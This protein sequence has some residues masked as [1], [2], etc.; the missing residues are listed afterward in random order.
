MLKTA[1]LTTARRR[2]AHSDLDNCMLVKDGI[3]LSL[4]TLNTWRKG[5]GTEDKAI[6]NLPFTR[7]KCSAVQ[8]HI[9][10]EQQKPTV[11][12]LCNAC[13]SSADAMCE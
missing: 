6:V 13:D 12:L 4:L 3:L 8:A 10:G 11:E 2:T 7:N 1:L 5:T 9:S